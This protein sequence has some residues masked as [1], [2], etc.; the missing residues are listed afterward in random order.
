MQK[1]KDHK[2]RV[3]KDGESYRDYENRYSYR[4]TDKQGKRHS[5]YAQ[6]LEELRKRE[7]ETA[8]DIFDGIRTESKTVTVNE[9]Y[10]AWKTDKKGLR[11]SSKPY[12][13]AFI[14]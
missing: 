10:E 6:T 12:K 9:M 8:N 3:L 11:S 7:A 4:W 5:I 14:R 13:N 2:G 1:R